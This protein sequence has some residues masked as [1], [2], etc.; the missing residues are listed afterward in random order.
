MVI[1]QTSEHPQMVANRYC[2]DSVIGQ[3]GMAVVYKVH[4]SATSRDLAL[5]LLSEKVSQRQQ[6]RAVELFE[7]EYFN[8]MHLAHPRVIEVYDYGIEGAT[9][10]YTMELLDGGDLRTLSPTH[11]RKACELLMDVCSALSLLHSRKLVHRDVSPRNIRCTNDGLAKLID[12]GAMIPMG[13]CKQVVGTPPFAA[14]EVVNL[15]VLDG[16]ADLYSLGAAMY[17]TLTGKNAFPAHDFKMLRQNWRRKPAVPTEL[18]EDIP[19]ALNDLVMSL[20]QIDATVRPA[21][22]AEVMERLSVI[23]DS[24]P[25]TPRNDSGSV[26]GGA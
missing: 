4:D 13:P 21:N 17:Y 7:R 16:R 24:S 25:P 1:K 11:W 22:A 20:L 9:P 18:L 6:D 8:L 26:S 14:P 5:K 12:F 3:G 10:Y 2:V 19:Q 15:Q 23:A